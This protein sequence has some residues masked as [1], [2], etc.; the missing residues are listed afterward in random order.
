MKKTVLLP[1]ALVAATACSGGDDDMAEPCD[2]NIAGNICTIAGS[3]E[4]GYDPNAD[5]VDIPAL[6]A[7]M[8]LPQDTVV[9]PDGTLYIADWNNHRIRKLEDGMLKWLAGRGEL[10]GT[11]DDPANNDFNHPPNLMLDENGEDLIIAAWHNSKVRRLNIA[12]KEVTDI[13]GDGKRA[14]FG[15]G[16]PAVMASLDLPASVARDP[17]GNLV[18]MDEANQVLRYIDSNGDIHLLAGQCIVDAPEPNGPG[19]CDTPVQ[20]PDGPNG[21]SGK[22][23]CGDPAVWCKKPCTPSYSGDEIPATEMRMAQPFGQSAIPAGRIVFDPDGNLYFADTSNNI[24]RM[25]DT[26]GIVHRVAGQAPEAGVAKSGYS[27]DGGPALDALLYAP[28]DLALGDDGTLYF[29]DVNN[30][31]V[32]KV[33]PDGMIDTVAGQCGV[34]GYD[35]DGGPATEAKMKI[36]FG[37]HYHDGRLYLADTGNN[38]IRTV[39]LP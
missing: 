14:Y 10:G 13:G 23:A 11:L 15:D 12:T 27:G 33:S 6:E 2:I 20:C 8:S 9:A 17:D 3:G 25:I 26:D 38:V 7:S 29:S 31:C 5:D 36:P 32:R 35:G 24:I 19:A 1:A 28:V 4:N 34:K 30:H 16:G 37:V 21:P 22:W 18:I 39:L